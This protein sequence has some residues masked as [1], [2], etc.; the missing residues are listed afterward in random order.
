MK[1]PKFPFQMMRSQF[2]GL[3]ILG[4]LIL[5]VQLGIEWYKS[6]QKEESILVEFVNEN[7]GEKRVLS[8]FN[9]ND[10]TAEGWK[11]LGFTDKQVKTILN[12]KEVVGGSFVSKEQLA[13]CYAISPEKFSELESY[14]LLPQKKEITH[15]VFSEKKKLNIKGKFNPDIYT[16]KDWES[17]GFTKKQA[18]AIVKYKNYLG[19]SFK[20]KEKFRESFVINDD[21]YLQLSPYLLLPEKYEE[22]KQEKKE[23]KP[24]NQ[25]F[26]FDPNELDLQGWQKL[27]FSERQAQVILNYKEKNLKGTFKTLEDVQRCFVISD[28]KFLELKPWIKIKV[29]EQ[30]INENTNHTKKDFSKIDINKLTYNDLLD[31]GFDEKATKSFLGFRKRLGGF[32]NKQQVLETYSIDKILAQKLIDTSPID[33][34]NVPKYTLKDAPEDFLKTHPYFRK[35]GEKIIFYRISFPSD[36]EI[37]SKI[38]VPPEE[39]NK[40]KLYLK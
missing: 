14:I 5:L 40:M 29:K 35:Y 25:Y 13:K 23:E 22:I 3:S 26:V 21:N 24:K 37:F 16:A 11:N 1:W 12:Y 31:F 34:N 27:G 20:S 28:E 33:V 6:Q 4:V 19:G 9:P 32:V 2:V 15:Q 36:K 7:S 17:I 18:E 38:K 8:K 30:K 39:I 10:L